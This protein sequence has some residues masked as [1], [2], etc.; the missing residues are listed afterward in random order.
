MFGFGGDSIFGLFSAFIS[1]IPLLFAG[2]L[3]LLWHRT[4]RPRVPV[5]TAQAVSA[6]GHDP[7]RPPACP[8][9]QWNARVTPSGRLELGGDGGT[10]RIENGWLGFHAGDAATPTWLVPTTRVRA[11]KNSMLSQGEVWV[12]TEQTGRLNLTVSHEHINLISRNDFKDLRERR[13]ADEFLWLLHQSG[14]TV[15]AA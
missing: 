4:R 15:V 12:E 11:G 14:A 10:I 6:A 13:Y 5:S 1:A 8:V 7:A 9:G 3:V 2:A